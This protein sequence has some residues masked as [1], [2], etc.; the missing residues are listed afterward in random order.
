M[1]RETG[2]ARW[3]SSPIRFYSP[4]KLTPSGPLATSEIRKV[5]GVRQ[6]IEGDGGAG[7]NP[8]LVVLDRPPICRAS[9]DAAI[10]CLDCPLNADDQPSSW[11]FIARRTSDF[12]QILA[13]LEREGGA[14]SREC[15]HLQVLPLDPVSI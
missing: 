11:R 5:D 4:V 10:V 1:S 14:G 3:D 13:H 12:R 2:R 7:T 9:N 15:L 8:L 6:V